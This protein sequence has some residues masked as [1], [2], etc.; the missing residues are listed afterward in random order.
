MIHLDTY[1]TS[2][3]RKKGRESKRQFDSQ[4]LKVGN[5]H[6]LLVCKGVPHIF[7]KFLM[8]AVTFLDTLPQAEVYKKCYKRPKWQESQFQEFWDS[9]LGSPKKNDI[10]VQPLW[11]V[12]ENIIRG[13]VVASPKFESWWVLQVYVCLW[14][15]Y[16]PKVF[17][18][19]TN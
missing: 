5:R 15:V 8:K 1:N 13:K 2:Y 4:P 9:Q 10:W 7:R 19:Y 16:A 18:L 3:G 17:Q 11:L 6:E 14:V 12:I